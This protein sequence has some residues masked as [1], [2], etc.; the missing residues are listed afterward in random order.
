M[1]DHEMSMNEL[2]DYM[3]GYEYLEAPL[4]PKYE[5]YHGYKI[6]IDYNDENGYSFTLNGQTES[7]FESEDQA[8]EDACNRID[9]MLDS[10]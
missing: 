4:F 8:I 10:L 9:A 2:I 6:A 7:G 5:T 1:S 3:P